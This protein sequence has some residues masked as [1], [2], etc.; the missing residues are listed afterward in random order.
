MA[1]QS[2]VFPGGELEHEVGRKFIPVALDGTVQ[3]LGL[4]A[5]ELGEV[6]V[7]TQCGSTKMV[8]PSGMALKRSG[9]APER[10]PIG[11][12]RS[13]YALAADG[14]DDAFYGGQGG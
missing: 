4:N 12:R 7:E 8:M 14:V 1:P 3:R 2:L 6:G 5:V 10:V 13:N 9:G 11:R